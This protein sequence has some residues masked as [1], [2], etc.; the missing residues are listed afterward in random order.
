MN[1]RESY[2]ARL[3]NVLS[4]TISSAQAAQ[5][6]SDGDQLVGGRLSLDSLEMLSVFAGIEQEFAVNFSD[7]EVIELL[8]APLTD[9]AEQIRAK[10][11]AERAHA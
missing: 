6:F 5:D 7:H 1:D 8:T 10:H 2:V 3:T 4:K 9:I 11:E